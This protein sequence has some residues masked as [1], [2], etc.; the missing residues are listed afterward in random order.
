LRS[1]GRSSRGRDLIASDSGGGDD[2][3]SCRCPVG[4]R[5]DEADADGGHQSVAVAGADRLFRYLLFSAGDIADDLCPE[6]AL[7]EI[8]QMTRYGG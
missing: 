4:F 8:Q 2:G 6:A 7:G 3:P 5:W 1:T